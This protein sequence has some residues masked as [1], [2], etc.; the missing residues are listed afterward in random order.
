MELN[1]DVITA[2]ATVKEHL[3][4]MQLAVRI[5][6]LEDLIESLD[7]MIFSESTKQLS[8]MIDPDY[9]SN[10]TLQ[11]KLVESTASMHA[12]EHVKKWAKSSVVFY[13]KELHK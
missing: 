2:Q 9:S 8:I 13:R 3:D 11:E 1:L 5:K 4:E 7:T 12:F 10:P 6:T